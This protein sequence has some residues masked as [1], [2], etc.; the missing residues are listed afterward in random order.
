[1]RSWVQGLT[2]QFSNFQT[3]TPNYKKYET[4][5]II[6]KPIFKEIALDTQTFDEIYRIFYEDE[7]FS[8]LSSSGEEDS[9][10]ILNNTE[11]RYDIIGYD[12][13][14]GLSV[15]NYNEIS[16][17]IDGNE[18]QVIK[19]NP[20]VILKELFSSYSMDENFIKEIPFPF[21]GGGIGYF[22]YDLS[23]NLE[24]IETNNKN[25]SSSKT[26]PDLSFNFFRLFLI[27]D[28]HKNRKYIV[29]ID[30]SNDEKQRDENQKLRLEQFE[31]KLMYGMILFKDEKEKKLKA[32]E[33]INKSLK[34]NLEKEDFLKKI[35]KI[36]DHILE[37][38][39]YILNFSHR[40]TVDYPFSKEEL[41]STLLV[42]NPAMYSAFLKHGDFSVLS[43]SPELFL[44]RK[45]EDIITK[46][47]KGTIEKK[48]TE[49]ENKIQIKKLLDSE[50]EN[51]ELSMIVDLERND[52]GKICNIGTV[53]VEKHREIMEL[54]NLFHTV[55]TVTGKIEKNMNPIDIIT[56]MF[57]GGSIT[58]TPKI[59]AMQLIEELEEYKRGVYTGS[60]GYVGFNGDILLNIAIRTM[61]YKDKKI[62]FSVGGGI[63][64]DSDPEAEYKETLDKAK[65][66]ISAIIN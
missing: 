39:V 58:G 3:L 5:M 28:K 10:S 26:E 23:K 44:D 49:E 36:K 35:E 30:F 20:F 4:S 24:K 40:F 38:D 42:E 65:G 25:E 6:L 22:G 52:L 48:E 57:P 11:N 12:S 45:G 13:F 21:S 33:E 64:L 16:I 29:S 53:K 9:E 18:P 62:N 43:S 15:S 63:V 50:K 55:S 2:F 47:I 19:E 56:A 59:K 1:M 7:E 51:A 34:S 31:K 54:P 14:L 66:I 32:R 8:I 61:I 17:K 27:I 46:P 37:G 41:F 60:V